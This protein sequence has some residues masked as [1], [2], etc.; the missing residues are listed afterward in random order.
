MCG[1]Y[2][3]RSLKES[4]HHYYHHHDFYHCN[5]NESQPTN[6]TGGLGSV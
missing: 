6:Q 4:P 1:T 5:Y 2:V 3:E